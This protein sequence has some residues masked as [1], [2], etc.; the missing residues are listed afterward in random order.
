M[1][2]YEKAS[3][4]RFLTVYTLALIAIIALVLTL[5]TQ[6]KIEA[7]KDSVLHELR[8][9]AFTIASRAIEAQMMGKN[10][11]LPKNIIINF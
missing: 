10:F 2:S 8:S 5:Y 4:K 7:L 3:L 6:I 9:Q 11:Q 1:H